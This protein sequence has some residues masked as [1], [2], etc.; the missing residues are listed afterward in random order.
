MAS[1]ALMAVVTGQLAWHAVRDIPS[2][3]VAVASAVL[4][5]RYRVNSSWLMIAAALTGL[6][7]HQA[8]R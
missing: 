5:I 3:L 4:L 7:I 8:G 1:L 6:A 2:A